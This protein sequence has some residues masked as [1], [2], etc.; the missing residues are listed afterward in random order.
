MG[1]AR[2][3]AVLAAAG[4]AGAMLAIVG[5]GGSS[6]GTAVARL[7]AGK[8]ADA[9][10]SA[11]AA[12]AAEGNASPEQP[13]VAYAKCM[14]ANGVPHFP[15]PNANGGFVLNHGIDPASPFLRAARTKCQ[16]L[17][18]GGGIGSGPPPPAQT[19]ARFLKVSAC[20]RRAGV[21]DFPDPG[22]SAP[23]P[24]PAGV[25]TISDIEGVIFVFAND[26]D[27]SSP[28]FEQA[29]GACGFPLHNH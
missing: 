23:S 5:C 18:P 20:M 13:A 9:E 15:D 17:V 19:L 3:Y 29:A 2:R 16:R 27:E 12:S 7:S 14:R 28:A 6:G 26:I 11:G 8:S 25:E 22:T 24:L 1:H 21:S 4:I 10:S